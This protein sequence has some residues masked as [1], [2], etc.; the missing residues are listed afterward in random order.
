LDAWSAAIHSR[1]SP[2]IVA[3]VTS[4][5]HVV[6]PSALVETVTFA[7]LKLAT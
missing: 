1:S 7:R 4:L 3:L 2:G 5:L 6:P